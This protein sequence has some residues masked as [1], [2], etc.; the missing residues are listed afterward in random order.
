LVGDSGIDPEEFLLMFAGDRWFS[1]QAVI[2][3][4]DRTTGLSGVCSRERRISRI[5]L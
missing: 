3:V 2:R 1:V 4:G 5:W